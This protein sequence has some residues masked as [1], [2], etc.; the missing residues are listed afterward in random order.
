[1]AGQRQILQIFIGSPGDVSDEREAARRVCAELT[2]EVGRHHGW[3]VLAEGWEQR[4]PGL[5]RA[6]DL[7]NPMVDACD[8][9]VGVLHKR[10]GT[11]TGDHS[12]GF[13]EE[14]ARVKQRREAGEH[15]DAFIYLKRLDPG[16]SRAADAETLVFREEVAQWALFRDYSE[17][18]GFGAILKAHLNDL[19]NER[20]VAHDAKAPLIADTPSAD[21]GGKHLAAQ[22]SL[23]ADGEENLAST[24]ARRA[25]LRLATA[26]DG[27]DDELPIL[28]VV[29]AHLAAAAEVSLRLSG[30]VMDIYDLMRA[31]D[32]RDDLELGYAEQRFIARTMA[33]DQINAPGWGLLPRQVDALAGLVL[34]DS[35]ADV[36]AGALRQLGAPGL[37]AAVEQHDVAI[38]DLYAFLAA[39]TE[40]AVLQSLC[41]ILVQAPGDETALT[42]ALLA[43][44]DRPAAH[45]AR[46]ALV[47]LLLSTDPDSAAQLL[48]DNSYAAPK[49][50]AD[51][52]VSTASAVSDH[53]LVELDAGD[54]TSRELR[55]RLLAA[56]GRLT[57]DDVVAALADKQASVRIEAAQAAL[58]AEMVLKEEQV[59]ELARTENRWGLSERIERLETTWLA[60][61]SDHELLLRADWGELGL[62]GAS[63]AEE[64]LRR[65]HAEMLQ[66]ARDDLAGNVEARQTAAIEHRVQLLV[67]DTEIHGG[68]QERA[69]IRE[70]IRERS[71]TLFDKYARLYDRLWVAGLLRGLVVSGSEKDVP[72]ACSFI[73]HDAMEVRN[74]AAR[75][76]MNFG[77]DEQVEALLRYSTSSGADTKAALLWAAAAMPDGERLLQAVRGAG[78][79]AWQ[80]D[81]VLDVLCEAS[82]SLSDQTVLELMRH[83]RDGVRMAALRLAV[84]DGERA[85]ATAWL[86]KMAAGGQRYF[87]VVAMLDRLA[88]APAPIIAVARTDLAQR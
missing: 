22:P 16:G 58:D 48:A 30:S 37:A 70:G 57:S 7:I 60:A 25:L 27:A 68:E 8:V 63:A 31:Y 55:L 50:A 74:A 85:T 36:Q 26:L 54:T 38:G 3:V 10:W 13:A 12:S 82:L 18:D 34:A 32:L 20:I 80:Q 23:A 21:S 67:V 69:M 78:L 47:E 56:S 40:E 51:R 72:L 87:D 28:D 53:T 86:H 35:R 73:D 61:Q 33:G 71:G 75:I 64:L 65:G 6:Q 79:E 44:D 39:S 45:T 11:P 66:R 76:L 29:R 83:D 81:V 15:V 52:L 49:D 5:G 77:A 24:A 4:R 19:L 2:H 41:P 42:L 17:L 46:S 62:R 9:F 59:S 14:V 1:M 84:A 43:D 88:Y